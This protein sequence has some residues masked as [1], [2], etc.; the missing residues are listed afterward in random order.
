MPLVTSNLICR[1]WTHHRYYFISYSFC[2]H[3][4]TDKKSHTT[5]NVHFFWSLSLFTLMWLMI[6]RVRVATCQS[7]YR[8][9]ASFYLKHESA[10]ARTKFHCVESVWKTWCLLC[11]FHDSYATILSNGCHLGKCIME[12]LCNPYFNCWLKGTLLL[13]WININQSMD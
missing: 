4:E 5:P 7:Q 8:K 9:Y 6:S 12:S 1:A 2:Y 13:T 10:K 3:K 11:S